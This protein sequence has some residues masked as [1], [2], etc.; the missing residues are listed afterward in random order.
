MR[1]VVTA[2]VLVMVAGSL[3]ACGGTPDTGTTGTPGT[4]P[5]GT[6]VVAT[7]PA[8]PAVKVDIYSPTQ[9][10]EPGKMFPSDPS[11]VPS[12]VIENLTA[13]K[14]MLVYIFDPTT[15]VASDQRREINAAIRK[16]RGDIELVTFD[17]TAGLASEGT[18][19]PV[20]LNKAELMTGVLR[21]NT[22]PYI[23]FVDGSGRITY[24]FAGFV[25]RGLLEREVLRATQ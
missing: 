15:K 25:D 13:K 1:R 24:R 8:A 6:A 22:T 17:Y 18:T 20:E 7:A 2:L 11:S 14:P 10:V 4:T 21:V 9:T 12:A 16:Y 5:A 23:V 19:L 3:A